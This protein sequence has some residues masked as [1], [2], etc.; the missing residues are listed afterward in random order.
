MW[1]R[2]YTQVYADVT[3]E[4]VWQ[5]WADIN[6]WHLWH[7]DLDYCK[8]DDD[9]V[10]GNHFILKPK[11]GPKV[12]IDIV[13][14]EKERKFVD[15]TRFP[16]AKM[17]DS[18]EVEETPEGLCIINTLTVTGPLKFLWIFLVAK[19]VAASVPKETA[20]LVALARK[21]RRV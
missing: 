14:I 10:V 1:V 5:L 4:E 2:K 13:E 21:K 9:F 15:C 7:D 3:K 17:Y 20:A 6:N 16:G 11:G 18:H 19:N 8:L 12:K